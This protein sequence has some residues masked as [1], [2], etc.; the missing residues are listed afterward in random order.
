MIEI[1]LVNT[2]KVALIDNE[3]YEKICLYR[4]WLRKQPS[5][6]LHAYTNINRK[7]TYMHHVIMGH[8]RKLDHKDTNGLNNQKFNLRECTHSQNAANRRKDKNSSSKF[9]GVTFF[10]RDSKWQA[11]ITVKYKTIHL[12]YFNNEVDAA[13]S[14]DKAALKYFGEFARTNEYLV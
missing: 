2:D 8:N 1:N 7:M 3:D 14:Y 4:W 6:N 11:K 9:K 10:K 5:G 12:G 13:K